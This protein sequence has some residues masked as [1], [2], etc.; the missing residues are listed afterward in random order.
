MFDASTVS[1]LLLPNPLPTDGPLVSVLIPSYNY[2]RFVGTALRSVLDQTYRNLEVVIVDDCSTD[3]ALEIIRTT[4]DGDPRVTVHNNESNLGNK[5]NFFRCYELSS[6]PLVKPLL[7]DDR[8]HPTAIAS[9]VAALQSDPSLT[10]AMSPREFVNDA[11]ALWRPSEQPSTFAPVDIS[12]DGVAFGNLML[13]SLANIV[14]EPSTVMWRR[15]DL[16]PDDDF[17]CIGGHYPT[18]VFD[19][20]WWLKLM[21]KG[22]VAYLTTTLSQSRRHAAQVSWVLQQRPSQAGAWYS[23]IQGAKNLGFLKDISDERVALCALVG[24]A[25]LDIGR[26]GPKAHQELKEMLEMTKEVMEK[27]GDITELTMRETSGGSPQ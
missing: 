12:I 7:A 24:F 8:L 1:R 18:A 11:G 15:D 27:V 26:F 9:F 17:F 20:T 5:G 4:A 23:I 25:L 19:G 21:A 2:D 14:G 3:R 13:T 16:P 22:K 6:G 10:L